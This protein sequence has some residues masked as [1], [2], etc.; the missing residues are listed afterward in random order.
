MYITFSHLPYF[1]MKFTSLGAKVT[2]IMTSN[3]RHDVNFIVWFPSCNKDLN[4]RLESKLVV[5]YDICVVS[6]DIYLM[7]FWN[8]QRGLYVINVFMRWLYNYFPQQNYRSY[9]LS[10]LPQLKCLDFSR[11]TKADRRTSAFLGDQIGKK[12]KK[13]TDEDED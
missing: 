13:K 9:I 1:Y 12:K 6:Y 7:A 3:S 4:V 5:S 11:V 8:S 2:N 10:K